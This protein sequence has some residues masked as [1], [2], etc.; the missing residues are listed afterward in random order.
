MYAQY[1][2]QSRNNYGNSILPQ[3]INGED[4]PIPFSTNEILDVVENRESFRLFNVEDREVSIEQLNT[5][6]SHLQQCINF[7]G[8][9]NLVR[10]CFIDHAN[11][12]E[13]SISAQRFSED[14]WTKLRDHI[15]NKEADFLYLQKE[16]HYASGVI[17]F[18]WDVNALASRDNLLDY[19]YVLAISGLLGHQAS[20]VVSKMSLKG[21]VF[22]G[23]T[24][25]EFLE[26]IA[27]DREMNY[28]PV[29]AY[30]IQ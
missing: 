29:F 22:A 27:R 18:E 9:T 12:F 11:L 20:L 24:L 5:I 14:K 21:T 2:Q 30:A 7:F 19:K 8:L 13:E 25:V 23:I 4:F 10:I 16:M 1:V 26:E 15:G 6:V 17:Y 3:K 28:L